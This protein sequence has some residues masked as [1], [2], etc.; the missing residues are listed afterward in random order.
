MK[1]K[2]IFRIFINIVKCVKIATVTILPYVNLFFHIHTYS[3]S[4]VYL[5]YLNFLLKLAKKTVMEE[6]QCEKGKIDE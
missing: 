5:E 3:S 4:L 6:K 2:S 1:F